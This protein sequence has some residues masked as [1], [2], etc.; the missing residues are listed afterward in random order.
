MSGH[1]RGSGQ[2]AAVEST[3]IISNK[4]CAAASVYLFTVEELCTELFEELVQLVE[5]DLLVQVHGPV[6]QRQLHRHA[7]SHATALS[8]ASTLAS[9]HHNYQQGA[10]HKSKSV[11]LYN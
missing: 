9:Q 2:R 7:L 10:A 1:F 5:D 4:P 11:D 6:R 3:I 8:A